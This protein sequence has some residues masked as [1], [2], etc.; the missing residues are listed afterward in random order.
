MRKKLTKLCLLLLVVIGIGIIPTK[1]VRASEEILPTAYNNLNIDLISKSKLVATN[2]GYMRVFYDGSKICIEYYDDNFSIKSKKSIEMELEIWGGF[3]AG[4]NAYYVV[5]GQNNTDENNTAEVIRVIKYDTNWNKLG[6]AK[7][8][9]NP[10]LFGGEVRYPFDYGCVEMCENNGILYIVTGHEGYVDDSVGQ[11]HQ[12]FLMITVNES[13][14]IGEIVK[15]DLWHS[16]AQ[17]IKCKESYLYVLEQ[18]EGDRNTKLSKYT[19][20]ELKKES[21]SVLDYGGSR[22]SAWAVACYASVD[23]MELSSNN[24]LCLGTSI[25]QSK[26]DSVSSDMAHNI[27]LTVTSMNNFSK[28]ATQVKWLTNYEGNGKCFL[29][30]KITKVND[31][32]FMISWEEYNVSQT[33]NTDD[34]LSESILHYVFVDGSGNKISEEFTAAAPISDCHPIVKNS[35][36]VF[37]AS[38]E[39]MVNFYIIDGNNGNFSKKINR[40][41]GENITW[42]LDNG[43]LT[44]SGTG[45]ITVDTKAK[46]RR[47]VSS[48]A[49]SHSY[50]S[51]DNAWKTIRKE[52]EKIVIGKGITSIPDNSFNYF[53]NL[54][55][56]EIEDGVKSIGK[57][58]FYSCDALDKIT[59][60]S[61]VTSIGEDFLWTGSSWM[62]SNEHVVRATIHAASDSYAIKYAKEKGINFKLTDAPKLDISTMTINNIADQTYTG[63]EICPTIRIQNG[64]T[65]LVSGEDYTVSYSNNTN[66]GKA[67]VTITGIGDY[68]G[69]VTKYFNIVEKKILL[70]ISKMTISNIT[71]QTYT[72][73]SLYPIIKIQNGNTSLVN[74]RDYTV[75]Y[76]NNKNIGSGAVT[77]TGKGNYTGKITRYFSIVPQKVTGV[78][79]KTQDTKSIT[80]KWNK[81]AGATWYEVYKYDTSKKKYIKV[82]TTSSNQYKVTNLKTA[83]T[84]QFKVR[85]YKTVS[86]K[87]YYSSYSSAIKLTTKTTTPKISKVTAGKKKAT[88]KWGKVTGATGYEIYMSTNKSKNY[89]RI[90]TIT[91]GK[92][93]KYTK[94][95]LK[96]GKK[97]YFKIRTYRTVNGKKIY[98]SYSSVKYAKV[99]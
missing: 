38:N 70:D 60:P 55:E 31:N 48:T 78:T 90:K 68:T 67:T 43:L 99:K 86:G 8:T 39:N 98:S 82:K 6:T 21:I 91:N 54:K 1:L 59:I 25:D 77:I 5:E 24:A 76:S 2:S 47:P 69:K 7:I 40:V 96:K 63:K 61:S 49:R 9:S 23:D 30:T 44:L 89:S 74:G 41:A 87:N 42:K 14:M 26:Y 92:T 52:V 35:K 85:A 12:G 79:N 84:Y 36:I 58:A 73:K 22:T 64:N 13:T 50:S 29:G 66:I 11:G 37:Y 45:D 57:E 3:F 17:Y 46:H 95:K 81:T 10:S 20:N 32:R 88:V 97:Y 27:Y 83:T 16:F 51:S 18:S 53:S 93:I 28:E 33:A 71:D 75:S 62:G 56:V 94:T 65:S 80:V 4:E 72:G 34:T 19:E 15:S